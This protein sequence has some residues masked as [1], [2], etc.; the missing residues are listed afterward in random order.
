MTR[1]D[2]L[3]SICRSYLSRLFPFANNV[4]LGSWVDETIKANARHECE[5]TEAEVE[6]LGRALDDERLSRLE[7]ADALGK[8]YRKCVEDGDFSRIRK[9]KR[10]GIYSKISTLLNKIT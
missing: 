10:A 3:Q 4:G 6:L 1:N 5:A 8:S 9:L 7:V 2:R